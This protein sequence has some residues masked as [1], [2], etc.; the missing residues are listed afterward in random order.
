MDV[1]I[2]ARR[3]AM[4]D[5]DA[6]PR[7][8]HPLDPRAPRE[9]PEADGET[10]PLVLSVPTPRGDVIHGVDDRAAALGLAPGMRAT[11]AAVIHRDLRVARAA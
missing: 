10:G 1:W 9:G 11:D 8:P 3:R 6:A 7:E 5:A 4:A 2:R